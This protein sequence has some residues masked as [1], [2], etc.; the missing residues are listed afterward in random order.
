MTETITPFGTTTGGLPYPEPTDPVSAGANAIK[1]L[2]QALDPAWWR[3]ERL[4]QFAVG[5]GGTDVTVG[6]GAAAWEVFETNFGAASGV[7]IALPKAGVYS[8]TA[9]ATIAIAQ[10]TRITVAVNASGGAGVGMQ[11]ASPAGAGMNQ[12]YIATGVI[13]VA[14]GETVQMIVA[15]NSGSSANF[16]VAGSSRYATRFSGRWVG[17]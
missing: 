2:A 4:A 7:N 13:R 15:Q 16:G 11:L 1:A 6:A 12:A 14:A 3:C 8:V 9:A 17:P 10:G 5:G